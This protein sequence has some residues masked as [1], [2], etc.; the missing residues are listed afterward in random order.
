M[1]SSPWGHKELN[2][3]KQLT[4]SLS[5]EAFSTSQNACD[6]SKFPLTFLRRQGKKAVTNNCEELRGYIVKYL[7][8]VILPPSGKKSRMK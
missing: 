1:S 8:D 6:R 5:V 3:T 4:L 2:M 7:K